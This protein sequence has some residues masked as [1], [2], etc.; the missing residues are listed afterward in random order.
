MLSDIEWDVEL[1]DEL[2]ELAVPTGWST[3]E[4]R[5]EVVTFSAATLAAHVRFRVAPEG[6]QALVTETDVEAV[7][8]I[9]SHSS[10]TVDNPTMVV[11]VLEL[12]PT[13]W[14]RIDA[15]RSDSPTSLLVV[16]F[17]AETRVVPSFEGD[18][19]LRLDLSRLGKPIERIEDE[20]IEKCDLESRSPPRVSD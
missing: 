9:E 4:T 3:E 17:N 12:K 2:F 19:L 1:D 14:R 7:R 18:G 15:Y 20:Y 16:D 13:A 11:L 8:S 5:R 10:L 6:G